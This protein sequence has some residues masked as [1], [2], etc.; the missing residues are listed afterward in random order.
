MKIYKYKDVRNINEENESYFYQIILNNSI[1]CAKPNSLN[2]KDEFK[3]EIDC[4]KSPNTEKLLQQ[5]IM[6]LKYDNAASPPHHLSAISLFGNK[7]IRKIT[8]PI[9]DEMIQ[10]MR[11]DIGIA[12][13]SE[14]KNNKHLWNMYGG[15]GNGA[16]IEIDIPCDLLGKSFFRVKYVKKKRYHIDSFI[17]A[18]LYNNNEY[19]HEIFLLTKTKMWTKEKEIRFVSKKQDVNVHLDDGCYISEIILG[20]NVPW[21]KLSE[22]ERNISDHC[23]LNDIKITK[24]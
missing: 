16:C 14:L 20:K 8:K 1:W 7:E 3:I 19:Y 24:S 12:S 9:I 13:F 5:F 15:Q 11:N 2:D 21:D 4:N 17:E 22:I 18:T 10:K 6:N 23:N